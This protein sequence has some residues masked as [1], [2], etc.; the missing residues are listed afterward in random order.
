MHFSPLPST[1]SLVVPEERRL[2]QLPEQLKLLKFSKIKSIKDL[3]SKFQSSLA[4][5]NVS[6]EE[7]F[8]GTEANLLGD[9]PVTFCFLFPADLSVEIVGNELFEQTVE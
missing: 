5:G 6:K 4:F 1:R 9:S 7:Y 8:L 2:Y 3:N